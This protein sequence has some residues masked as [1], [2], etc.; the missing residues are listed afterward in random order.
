MQI[1]SKCYLQLTSSEFGLKLPKY[2]KYDRMLYYKSRK[3]S[4][5]NKWVAGVNEKNLNITC[6]SFEFLEISLGLFNNWHSCNSFLSIITK[7]SQIRRHQQ[8]SC[9]SNLTEVGFFLQLLWGRV[10][11]FSYFWFFA[12]IRRMYPIFREKWDKCKR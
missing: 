1:K 12:K 5:N 6:L 3:I 9:Q 10:E 8:I 4:P 7:V 11:H 2:W